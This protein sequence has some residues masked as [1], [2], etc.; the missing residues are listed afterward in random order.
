MPNKV[1]LSIFFLTALSACHL[2]NKDKLSKSQNKTRTPASI[3]RACDSKFVDPKQFQCQGKTYLYSSVICSSGSYKKFFCEKNYY[4]SNQNCILDNSSSTLA[5]HKRHNQLNEELLEA[6]KKNQIESVQKLLDQSADVNARNNNG[7]TPLI[8]ASYYGRPK[9]AQILL[10]RG[11]L[12]N[13]QNNN[14]W[15]SLMFAAYYGHPEIVHQLLNKG[16]DVHA[17]NNKSETA[18][19]LASYYGRANIINLIEKEKV[20]IEKLQQQQF[21]FSPMP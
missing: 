18:S 4:I 20:R 3:N 15:N 21:S 16:I 8:L 11:A 5:C 14:G 17:K 9:I 1:I 6:V 13:A 2:I 12:V 19:I 7:E 10:N